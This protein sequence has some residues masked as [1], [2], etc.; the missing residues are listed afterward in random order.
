MCRNVMNMRENKKRASFF[1]RPQNFQFILSY[2]DPR[3]GY[4]AGKHFPDRILAVCD[5]DL[6]ALFDGV[7]DVFEFCSGAVAP[8]RDAPEQNPL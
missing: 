1:T 2:A 3:G 6:C 8:A 7:F 5:N 4:L